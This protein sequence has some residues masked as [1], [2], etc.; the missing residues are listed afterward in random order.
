MIT[1]PNPTCERRRKPNFFI[2]GAPKSGTSAMSQYLSEHPDIY[3]AKKEMNF[4]GEDLR[5]GRRIWRRDLGSYLN[6]FKT[7]NSQRR[8]GE[9]SV[10]YLFSS[11]AAEE[12]RA[13]DPNSR[14]IVMLREP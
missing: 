11:R 4:F 5:F 9:A 7:C 3:M 2:V 1:S 14:I 12:I 8:A 6:E 13:F 10:W